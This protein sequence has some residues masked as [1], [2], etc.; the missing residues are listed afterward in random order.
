MPNY[1]VLTVQTTFKTYIT[2]LLKM[3]HLK[4]AISP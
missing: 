4:Q 3:K 2:R 1:V